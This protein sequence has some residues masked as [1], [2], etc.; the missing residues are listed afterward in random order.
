MIKIRAASLFLP[1]AESGTAS[2][3]VAS[4]HWFKTLLFK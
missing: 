4:Q 3:D 1:G 2:I